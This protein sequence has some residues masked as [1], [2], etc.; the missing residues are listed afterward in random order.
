MLRVIGL[1]LLVSGC[2]AAQTPQPADLII[3]NARVYTVD[4]RNPTAEAVAVAGDRIVRVGRDADVLALRGAATR[5]VD[6]RQTALIP[7]LHDAHGHVAGFGA[8]LQTLDLRGT[9]S[10]QQIVDRV[11]KRAAAAPRG[12]WIL[13]R[14]WDQNDW[15]ETDR[16]SHEALSAASPDNPV[17]LTRVDG[18]AA[19]VNRRALE[20]AGIAGA[21]AD[22]PGGRIIRGVTGRPS[23]V[24][25]DRAQDLV[26][27]RIPPPAP[28][29]IEARIALADRELRRLGVTMVHD[30]GIDGATLEAYQRM[31]E[32]GAFKTR[33][34]AML[35]GSV[36]QLTPVLEK[37]PVLDPGDRLTVRAVKIVADGALGSRGAALL[38]PYSDEPGTTGLLTT[39]PGDIYELALAAVRAGFQP[40]VHA[41]GDRA[42]RNVLDTFERLQLEVP[43]ARGLRLR[44][45]HAQ[46]LDASDI[47]RFARLGL[48][49]SMQPAHATSDMPW[50]PA[51]IG[52]ART[53][54][55]AYV[56]QRLL[57]MGVTIAAGSDFPVEEPDPM[58]GFHAAITRQDA[59]GNPP[60]GWTADQRMTREQAL[61]AFTLDAAYAAHADSR[62]GSIQAGKLADLV[63]LSKDIMEVSPQEILTTEVNLT[64]VGGEIVHEGA[65]PPGGID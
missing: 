40:C 11:R 39:P 1:A 36:G 15:Q 19:L 21:T 17:F 62:T 64:V 41:I 52:E 16:P 5:V 47:P 23:G 14:S 60:G 55:G 35:R 18:H 32:R 3:H 10:Y 7:G 49:A 43:D 27:S 48:V 31:R 61:K 25:I 45:E 9:T 33:V 46:I 50:V 65:G 22:P 53:Q 12:E 29:D 2:A 37:G 34:Y 13:G 30:A 51:R 20:I 38:D 42:N 63:L 59:S 58:L 24:L 8:S 28:S 6:A 54:E 26:A 56:W 44:V 4:A 57:A